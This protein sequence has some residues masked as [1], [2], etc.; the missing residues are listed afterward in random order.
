MI[1]TFFTQRNT[2]FPY[3]NVQGKKLYNISIFLAI[4]IRDAPFNISLLQ[5]K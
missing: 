2:Q 5:K 4:L 3:Y 1:D